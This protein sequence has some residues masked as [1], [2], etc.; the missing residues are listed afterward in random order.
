MK[1][2]YHPDDRKEPSVS[3]VNSQNINQEHCNSKI[4]D[5]NKLQNY[6]THY[7]LQTHDD[8]IASKFVPKHV[9]DKDKKLS[10]LQNPK[11]TNQVD[12][13]NKSINNDEEN[14]HDKHGKKYQKDIEEKKDICLYSDN[15][16]PKIHLHTSP[17]A[18]KYNHIDQKF[19][20]DQYHIQNL[21]KTCDSDRKNYEIK[22]EAQIFQK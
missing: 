11:R 8:Y 13:M 5:Y 16:S 2:S 1:R 17:N 18:S 20:R 21:Q 7:K 14:Y 22:Q 12:Y 9:R 19:S 15:Q 3:M 6:R 10:E 4:Q